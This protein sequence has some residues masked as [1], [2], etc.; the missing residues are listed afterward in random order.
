[1]AILRG[2]FHVKTWEHTIH[3]T[4]ETEGEERERRGREKERERGGEGERDRERKGQEDDA[5]EEERC[6][7]MIPTRQHEKASCTTKAEIL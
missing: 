5:P 7:K 2:I 3:K 6:R 1:M 4:K